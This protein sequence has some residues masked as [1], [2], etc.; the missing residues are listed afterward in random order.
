MNH[1]LKQLHIYSDRKLKLEKFLILISYKNIH[2]TVYELLDKF[3]NLSV[4]SCYNPAKSS[5][6]HHNIRPSKQQWNLFK[7]FPL[8]LWNSFTLLKQDMVYRLQWFECYFQVVMFFIMFQVQS[9]ALSLRWDISL[10]DLYEV[11]GT[12]FELV[13]HLRLPGYIQTTQIRY[14]T[15]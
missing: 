4:V 8:C 14:F 2:Q 11:D 9:T 12:W 15:T 6:N 1:F 10:R 13:Q 7:R 5:I 3:C